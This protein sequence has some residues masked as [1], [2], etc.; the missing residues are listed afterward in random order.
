MYNYISTALIQ[1]DNKEPPKHLQ[2]K[3][4]I[5]PHW[6]TLSYSWLMHCATSQKVTDSITDGVN[7]I[8]HWQFFQLHYGSGVDS[9]SNRNEYQEYFLGVKAAGV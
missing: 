4:N 1:D 3:L 7:G 6:G 8:F 9:A 5:W 2:C